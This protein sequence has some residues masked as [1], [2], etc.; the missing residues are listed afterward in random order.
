[1]TMTTRIGQRISSQGILR[2]FIYTVGSL[3]LLI[4]LIFIF[5][6]EYFTSFPSGIRITFGVVIFLYGIYRILTTYTKQKDEQDIP[7]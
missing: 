2:I 5:A 3:F 1:M 6:E 7:L 4:G